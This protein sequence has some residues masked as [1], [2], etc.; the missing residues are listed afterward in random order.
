LG[1]L[2]LDGGGGGAPKIK[3]AWRTQYDMIIG[4]EE[5]GTCNGL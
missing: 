1:A 5:R 2:A 4:R 3:L